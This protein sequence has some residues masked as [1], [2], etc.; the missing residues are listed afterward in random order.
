MI[1]SY[2]R[3]FFHNQSRKQTPPS[4]SGYLKNISEE[5][6]RLSKNPSFICSSVKRPICLRASFYVK[7]FWRQNNSSIK[8]SK[9]GRSPYCPSASASNTKTLMVFSVRLL[10]I[11]ETARDQDGKRFD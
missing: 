9:C 2:K 7:I 10:N 1:F 6:S 5:K 11:N 3:H 8:K 4:G